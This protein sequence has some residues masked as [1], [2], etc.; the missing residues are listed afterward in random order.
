MRPWALV[1][2]PSAPVATLLR[3]FL[4]EAGL[5]VTVVTSAEEALVRA[6]ERAPALV[7]A[8]VSAALDGEA[9]CRQL[10][11]AP[12]P[13]PGVLLAYAP[14]LD[15][16]PA[17][18]ARARAEA[19]LADGCVVG[20]LKRA[21]VVSSCRLVLALAEA[22]AQLHA[23]HAQLLE[24]QAQAAEA[25]AAASGTPEG[26]STA[27]DY[28]FLERFLTFEARRSRRYRYPIALLRVA[29]DAGSGE[30]EALPEPQRA[31][32][33]A[34]MLTRVRVGVRD[35]DLAAQGPDGHV[36]VF[37]PHTPRE[38]ACVVA[39]RLR[40]RLQGLQPLPEPGAEAPEPSFSAPR[41]ASVGVA[42]F[43][44]AASRAPVSF[45]ELLLAATAAL[46]RAQEAGGN[47]VD[48]PE[49]TGRRDRISM[50]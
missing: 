26:S 34:A 25:R 16:G 21:T 20:P 46:A 31:A 45:P 28:A 33:A 44:P 6:R 2:E 22:R 23:A 19:A 12:A 50:G 47:R 24:A 29:L 30:A 27:A 40:E 35:I 8:A 9:L 41:T 3:S 14:E 42:V 43:E 10:K 7:L 38:G 11:A 1:A 49:R 37:L 5:E 18:G 13:A 48:A 39:E 15:A 4:E 17:G 36:L 32:L